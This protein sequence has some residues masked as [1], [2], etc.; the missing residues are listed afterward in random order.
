MAK[1]KSSSIWLV[2]LEGSEANKLNLVYFGPDKGKARVKAR[3]AL[4]GG[5]EVRV[6][7]VGSSVLLSQKSL[8]ATLPRTAF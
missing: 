6:M 5:Q 3:A 7:R 1:K 8:V 2:A 4:D